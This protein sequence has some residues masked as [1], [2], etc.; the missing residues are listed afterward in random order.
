MVK[1]MNK[2]KTT[3][4]EQGVFASTAD[5]LQLAGS[6]P[7]LRLKGCGARPDRS[8]VVTNMTKMTEMT[9]YSKKTFVRTCAHVCTREKVIYYCVISVIYVIYIYSSI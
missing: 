9:Q 1:P 6:N 4:M 2:K 5:I 3:N 8:I 7:V